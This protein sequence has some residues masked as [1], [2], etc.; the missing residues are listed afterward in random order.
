MKKLHIMIDCDEVLNNCV[1][2]WV[3]WLNEKYSL[4]V[5]FRDVREW[6]LACVFPQLT[7]EQRREP[8]RNEAFALSA[9][10]RQGSAEVLRQMMDDGHEVTIVTAHN[11]ETAYTKFIWLAEHFPFFDRD[12]VIIARKKQRIIGDV[13][14]D[15]FPHNLEGGAY[16]KILFDSPINRDFDTQANG[17]TRAHTLKEAYEIIIK[18]L[19]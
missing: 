14:I 6:N 18:E 1:E 5:N 3:G 2:H 15:D 19:T 12:D 13:L 8:L 16:F 17:M 10:V 9:K 7:L 4:S 11:N